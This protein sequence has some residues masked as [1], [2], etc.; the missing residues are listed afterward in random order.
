MVNLFCAINVT[1]VCA[2][3]IINNS[4]FSF[5]CYKSTF[6]PNHCTKRDCTVSC[7]QHGPQHTVGGS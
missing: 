6:Y 2:N 5:A 4:S 7:A 3:N 1:A